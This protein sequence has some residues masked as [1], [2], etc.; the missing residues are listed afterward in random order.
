ASELT[1]RGR[2]G[3][4]ALRFSLVEAVVVIGE[5]NVTSQKHVVADGDALDATD[6]NSIGEADAVANR[7]VWAEPLVAI[8]GDRLEPQIAGGV[9]AAAELHEFRSANQAT[10]AEV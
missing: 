3:R 5:G 2:L 9:N 4:Q 6:V 8:G 10:G 7:D 1:V